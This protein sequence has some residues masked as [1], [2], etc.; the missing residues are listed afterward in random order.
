MARSK[1]NKALIHIVDYSCG[2]SGATEHIT[3]TTGPNG[4]IDW[5]NCGVEDQ[6][7]HPPHVSVDDIISKDFDA[8]INEPGS[9]FQGCG[10]FV[11]FFHKYGYHYH[12]PPILLAS[13]ALQESF[14]DPGSVGEGG[15]QGIMQISKDKCDG[16]PGG[17][18]RDPDF[19]IHQGAKFFAQTLADNGGNIL[20]TLGMYNGWYEGLTVAKA[21]AAAGSSCCK[22]Q[23]NLDYLDQVFN[24]WLQ[25]IDPRGPHHR[26]GRF[27]NLD[28][29]P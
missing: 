10:P 4:A 13:I 24:G 27:F 3:P 1:E 25:G 26:L 18:C 17:D 20:K 14:C 7:W 29:C 15:E 22:C 19:N 23:N 6:G 5:L 8:A 28:Q 9:P 11:G 2:D 16:A 21:T 12:L